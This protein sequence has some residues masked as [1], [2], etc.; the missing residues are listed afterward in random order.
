MTT[1]QLHNLLLTVKTYSL[2]GANKNSP[3]YIKRA[4]ELWRQY[5][6]AK[7]RQNATTRILKL[8]K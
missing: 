4:R 3:H 1:I 8:V 6:T 2:L 5:N 7:K